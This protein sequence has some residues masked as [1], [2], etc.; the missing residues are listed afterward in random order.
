MKAGSATL[1]ACAGGGPSKTNTIFSSN[2]SYAIYPNPGSGLFTVDYQLNEDADVSVMVT[3]LLGNVILNKNLKV[4]SGF[5]SDVLDM[6]NY[7]NGMYIVIITTNSKT[8]TEKIQL[9]R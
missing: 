3:D 6:T 8:T 4:G 9:M 5:Y 2:E 7:E 1:G